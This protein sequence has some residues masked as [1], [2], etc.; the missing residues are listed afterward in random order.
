MA[1]EQT[2]PLSA[3]SRVPQLVSASHGQPNRQAGSHSA[4][5]AFLC[6]TVL[7]ALK[8]QDHWTAVSVISG[9]GCKPSV[10]QLPETGLSALSKCSFFQ[11]M[12]ACLCC[13]SLWFLDAFPSPLDPPHCQA[14]SS[15]PSAGQALRFSA[16]P[17]PSTPA[18]RCLSTSPVA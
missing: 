2:Q 13:K 8:Q 6:E 16:W 14:S 1:L 11:H 17:A 10:A 7:L 3:E 15:G 9:Q 12:C 5:D 4:R 18:R